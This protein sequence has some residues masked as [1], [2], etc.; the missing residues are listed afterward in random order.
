LPASAIAATLSFRVYPISGEAIN[1]SQAQL[2]ADGLGVERPTAVNAG[3]SQYGLILDPANGAILETIFWQLSNNQTWETHT[4]D[5]SG[6]AGQ[7]IMLHFGAY[8]DGLGGQ[9]GFYLDQS[10]LLI[11]Q[12]DIWANQSFLPIIVK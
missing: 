10:A 3:D 4:F 12:S 8:N 9:T 7:T 5:L 2:F 1:V 11:E 6:Y